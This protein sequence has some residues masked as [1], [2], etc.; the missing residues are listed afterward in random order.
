MAYHWIMRWPSGEDELQIHLVLPL[1]AWLP[2]SVLGVAIS[3]SVI[4]V[5]ELLKMP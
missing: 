1:L 2:R 4:V 5:G 3:G